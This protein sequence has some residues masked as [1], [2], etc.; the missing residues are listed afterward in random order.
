MEA[1]E[2]AAVVPLKSREDNRGAQPLTRSERLPFAVGSLIA[3]RFRIRGLLAVGGTSCLYRAWDQYAAS[4]GLDDPSVVIKVPRR[5]L[6]ADCSADLIFRE[7]AVA[8]R[9]RHSGVINIFDLHQHH[10]RFFLTQE[11]VQGESLRERLDRA[12]GQG[13]PHSACIA[14]G[15]QLVAA[16]ASL[17]AAGLVHSDIKPGNVLLGRDGQLRLIDLATARSSKPADDIT[18][19][20]FHGFSPAYASPQTLD[21]EPARPADD[22]YSLACVLY[23]QLAGKHPFGGADARR[24]RTEEQTPTRPPSLGRVQWRLLRRALAFDAEQRPAS[25]ERF[26][27]AFAGTRHLAPLA[28]M[29]VVIM[30]TAP[31]A[32]SL[33]TLAGSAGVTASADTAFSQPLQEAH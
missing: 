29:A 32:T 17:H 4:A 10:G 7:V 8:R 19:P 11:L 22:V 23:E 28:V 26:W 6:D 31:A 21:D 33:N 16:I 13:M 12:G 14:I 20:P 25:V 2:S 18:N 27:R 30:A 3:E 1:S 5:L 15:R 24:A 9:A